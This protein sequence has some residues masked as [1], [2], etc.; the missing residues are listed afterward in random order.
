MVSSVF[1][2]VWI[3][4][5]GLL[6]YQLPKSQKEKKNEIWTVHKLRGHKGKY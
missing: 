2:W 5:G 4:P 3:V 1:G 6:F